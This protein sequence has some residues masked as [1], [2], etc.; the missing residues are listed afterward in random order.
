MISEIIRLRE[1]GLSIRAIAR[2]LNCSR[3]TVAKYLEASTEASET[4]ASS[5]RAPWSNQID[6]DQVRKLAQVEG[7][8]L[9]D[10]W[11]RL[12]KNGSVAVPYVSFWREFK[13]R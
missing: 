10:V 4:T 2:A 7:E 12:A 9:S 13:R 8:P 1:A 5:Y 6:W 11:E 3:N